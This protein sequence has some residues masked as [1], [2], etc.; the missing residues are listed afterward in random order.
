MK[1]TLALLVC[2][3]FNV[4]FSQSNK[5]VYGSISTV[6]AGIGYQHQFHGKFSFDANANYLNL[7]P[8]LLIGFLTQYTHHRITAH[9]KMFHGEASIKWHPFG[10]EYYDEYERNKFFIRAGIAFKDNS[11]YRVFSDYQLKTGTKKFAPIDS[12]IGR[13][14]IMLN[15]KKIQPYLGLGFQALRYESNFIFNLEAGFFYHDQPDFTITE[16]GAKNYYNLKQSQRANNLIR[17]VI[18]YPQIKISFGYK[19]PYTYKY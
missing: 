5:A 9:V 19:I 11:K 1:Y 4:A 6:G 18:V 3:T 7:R 10:S 16:T 2:L 13:F 17:S 15:T 14:D 8:S 12:T